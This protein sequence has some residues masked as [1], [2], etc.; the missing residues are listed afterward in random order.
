MNMFFNLQN[1]S[2][3]IKEQSRK[4]TFEIKSCSIFFVKF[5]KKAKTVFVLKNSINNLFLSIYLVFSFKQAKEHILFQ[6][7]P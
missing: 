5:P 6:V 2:L 4:R 3:Y 7:K 1:P